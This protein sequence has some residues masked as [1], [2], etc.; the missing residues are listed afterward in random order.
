[1][2]IAAPGSFS[3]NLCKCT[4]TFEIGLKDMFHTLSFTLHVTY[5]LQDATFLALSGGLCAK[6][7]RKVSLP[8]AFL[9]CFCCML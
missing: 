2:F 8:S 5:L 7:K 9:L 6:K 4:R 3:E 1:M